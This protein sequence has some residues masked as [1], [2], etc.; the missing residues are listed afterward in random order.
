MVAK[1]AH[2]IDTRKILAVEMFVQVMRKLLSIWCTRSQP[3][4][5]RCVD[6]VVWEDRVL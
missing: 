1:I 3:R 5:A 6:H 4:D 2:D